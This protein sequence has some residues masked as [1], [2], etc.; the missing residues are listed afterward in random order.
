MSGIVA[1]VAM[2]RNV[3][4]MATPSSSDAANAEE[5]RRWNDDAWVATWLLREPLTAPVTPML[6]DAL[7]LQSGERVV[8]IGSGGGGGA[9]DYARA[10]G[11]AGSV[12]GVD[13]SEALVR[14]ARTRADEA[15]AGNVAFV[16][17]DAQTDVLPGGPFDVATSKLGVMFFDDPV[18]AFTNIRAYLRPGGRLVFV[19]FQSLERNPFHIGATLRPFMVDPPP[20]GPGMPGPFSLGDSEATAATLVRSGFADIG[21]LDVELT[22]RAGASAVFDPRQLQS[23]GV[24]PERF[25]EAEA[26]V[27]AH[28][29]RFQVAPDAYD[30]PLA[31]SICSATNPSQR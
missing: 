26:A 25:S 17:A 21:R 5:R 13:I 9:I 15:G 2:F 30:F 8:D 31:I 14:L 28:L 6:L 24:A 18:G 10:V 19:C 3:R 22:V 7:G 27:A 1:S 20:S 16:V 23:A 29:A 11:P 12:I 4:R